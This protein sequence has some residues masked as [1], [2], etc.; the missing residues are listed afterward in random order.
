MTN[1]FFARPER[2][3]VLCKEPGKAYSA[4]EMPFDIPGGW[5]ATPVLYVRGLDYF[6]QLEA[7]NTAGES[8]PA[9]MREVVRR[10][11]VRIEGDEQSILLEQFLANPHAGIFSALHNYI[12]GLT[13][14]N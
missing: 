7:E 5:V 4:H 2:A 12:H 1:A 14:G 3:V 9:L 13:W 6:S 11:V 8:R 10:A